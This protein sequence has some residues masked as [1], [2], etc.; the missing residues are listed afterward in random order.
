MKTRHKRIAGLAAVGMLVGGGLAGAFAPTGGQ[1]DPA[2][3][4]ASAL[5]NRTGD[6]VSAADVRG[7][8]TDI[9]EQ[10]LKENVASGRITQEQA[11]EMLKRAA[12]APLPGVGRHGGP[13]GHHGG[14]MREVGQ[15][16]QKLLGVT[17]E[18]MHDAREKG[19]TLA[20][21][22]ESKGVAKADLV[23]TVARAVKASDRGANLSDA[24]ATQRAT[25]MVD[26]KG[27]PRRAVKDALLKAL[28]VSEDALHTAREA[29]KSPADLAEEKGVDTA[30]AVTAVT[31]AL[32]EQGAPHGGAQKTDAELRQ[33]ATDIV[34]GNGPG[35]HGR[36]GHMPPQRP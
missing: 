20:Q 30:A 26:G 17:E 7:A 23:A 13:G 18:Q 12:S 15:A 29:G 35:G 4:L 28:G 22:A 25:D 31:A 27:G 2:G 1:D 36:A 5:S 3:D 6:Q 9:L 32:K 10:R 16:V 14:G 33:M 34:N 24:R 11:D 8:F 21:L 19:T